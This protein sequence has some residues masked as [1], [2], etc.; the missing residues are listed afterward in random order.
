MYGKS[1]KELNRYE[2]SMI[3]TVLPNCGC[4]Y[5]PFEPWCAA[6]PAYLPMNMVGEVDLG[7]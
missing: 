5:K 3:A 4:G 1:A 7:R 6:P 2:A